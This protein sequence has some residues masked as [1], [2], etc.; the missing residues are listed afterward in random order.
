MFALAY[1]FVSPSYGAFW[2]GWTRLCQGD[3]S[4]TVLLFSIMVCTRGMGNLASGPMANALLAASAGSGFSK[5]HG[6][7]GLDDGKWGATIVFTGLCAC[8]GLTAAFAGKIPKGEK[9]RQMDEDR[10]A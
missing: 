6:A 4:E 3:P 7:Y 8:V 5:A 9:E 1:G 2:S 10:A